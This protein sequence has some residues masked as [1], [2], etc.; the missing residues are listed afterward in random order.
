MNLVDIKEYPLFSRGKVRDMY[1]LDD[2]L[3]MVASDRISVYDVVL[4]TLIPGKGAILNDISIFWFNKLDVSHHF[5]TNN[6]DEYPADLHQYHDVLQ[7]RSMLIRK[8]K[9]FDVECV[10]RGYLVGSGYKDYL[11]TGFVCG[12]K[13]PKGLKNGSCLEPLLFTPAAKND[14]GHDE[15]IDFET[16]C[17]M[18][19]EDNALKLKD[20]TLNLYQEA[21]NFALTKGI[22][23][24]DTKFEFGE[25]D[26]EI[27]LIDEVLTPD[28]SRFWPADLYKEGQ[29]QP[30]LDKQFVRDHTA[31]CHWNKKAPG[32]ELPQEVIDKTLERYHQVKNILMDEG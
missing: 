22:I 29:E 10:A 20:L 6:V 4:P 23:I 12:H 8:A 17:Q 11:N 27:I 3:L 28:S 21:R 9:R 5:I 7:G 2:H 24:A 30:S 14:I 32:P 13:L 31:S 15:N 26:G 18:V 1:D 19:G 16:M 25:V